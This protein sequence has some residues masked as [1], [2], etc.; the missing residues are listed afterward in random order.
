VPWYERGVTSDA[1]KGVTDWFQ[2]TVRLDEVV[3][4]GLAA[5][6]AGVGGV[7]GVGGAGGGAGGGG[8]GGGD[9]AAAAG[10]AVPM[11]SPP[12]PPPSSSSSAGIGGDPGPSDG[13]AEQQHF[14]EVRGGLEQK[15]QHLSHSK[16]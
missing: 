15:I 16:K 12:P 14:L 1:L 2:S 10:G 7:G 3:P 8:G 13:I 11:T 5:S 9:D 4:G 6:V